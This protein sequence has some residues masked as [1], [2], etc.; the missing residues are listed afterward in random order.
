MLDVAKIFEEPW[1][2]GPYK[3]RV[4]S[5]FREATRLPEEQNKD[6]SSRDINDHPGMINNTCFAVTMLNK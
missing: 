1:K 4:T 6:L 5:C 2:G 3:T